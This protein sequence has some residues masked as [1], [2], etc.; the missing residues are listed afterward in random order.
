VATINDLIQLVAPPAAPVH[1]DGDWGAAEHALGLALPADYRALVATYGLGRFDDIT[2]FTPFAATTSRY[3][4]LVARAG[5]FLDTYDDARAD[6]PE[7]FPYPLHPEPGGLLPWAGDGNGVTL[8][9]LT[10]GAAGEWPV[11][12]FDYG[13]RC[14]RHDV[15]AVDFLYG[16]LSGRDRVPGLAEEDPGRWFD[17]HRDR[18]Q[19]YMRLS[20]GERPYDER[21][22]I[23]RAAL[24]PTADRGA[25]SDGRNRQDHFK[26][27]DRDWL[28]T[29]ETAYGH[30]IRVA[31]PPEDAATARAVVAAAVQEMGC[32]V[33]AT[34]THR[35]EPTWT[36]A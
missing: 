23:L 4:D 18:V 33:L 8:C 5:E 21:L 25:F 7:A 10:E 32:T 6:D 36:D 11:V 22:R 24:A 13:L 30:Q 19:V 15:G 29:Y 35:G 28:L 34:T 26:A 1:S 2:V 31:F 27:I 16:C 9:W 20:D 3:A 14:D 12:V 17:A